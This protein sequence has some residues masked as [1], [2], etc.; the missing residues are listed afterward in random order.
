MTFSAGSRGSKQSRRF[1][2]IVTDFQLIPEVCK[3]RDVEAEVPAIG[4]IADQADQRIRVFPASPATL[5]CGL[6]LLAWAYCEK[7]N[8]L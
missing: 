4:E 5:K 3:C 6:E 7:I 1:L 8:T 2:L